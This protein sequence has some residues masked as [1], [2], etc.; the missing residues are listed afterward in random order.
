MT[1]QPALLQEV[2]DRVL[3]SAEHD[4]SVAVAEHEQLAPRTDAGSSQ[5]PY[6]DLHPSAVIDSQ[7]CRFSDHGPILSP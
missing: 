1:L 6:R 3:G 4:T 5:E 7:F 2:A